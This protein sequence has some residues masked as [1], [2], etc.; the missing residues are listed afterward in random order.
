MEQTEW[1]SQWVHTNW[2]RTEW[3]SQWL[4]VPSDYQRNCS[5]FFNP[6][7]D[8]CLTSSVQLRAFYFILCLSITVS[9]IQSYSFGYTWKCDVTS[10]CRTLATSRDMS[11]FHVF[12]YRVD[13]RRTW[14]EMEFEQHTRHH[15]GWML[16]VWRHSRNEPWWTPILKW[17]A[18]NH[19]HGAHMA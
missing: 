9:V 17:K 7:L 1:N 11:K 14:E 5:G 16:P 2:Y 19:K 18:N 3:H 12:F 6:P 15:R 10:H 8:I 13:W 4:E